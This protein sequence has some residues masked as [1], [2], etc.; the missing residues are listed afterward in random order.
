LAP[1]WLG[2]PFL[3]LSLSPDPILAPCYF[4]RYYADMYVRLI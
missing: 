2:Y 1:L 4:T 3:V